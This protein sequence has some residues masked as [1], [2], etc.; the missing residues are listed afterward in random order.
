[1]ETMVEQHK[2]EVTAT[3]VPTT[4]VHPGLVVATPSIVMMEL[5]E[6]VDSTQTEAGMDHTDLNMA[7]AFSMGA[8]AELPSQVMP[9]EALEEEEELTHPIQA[10]GQE[11]D[12]PEEG[13]LIMVK[14]IA[15]AAAAH[16][17]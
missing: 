11:V 13:L 17:M 3:A 12:T 10:A 9:M 2:M 7:S 1:M 8:R 6:L 15:A 5:E 14:D 16:S 4:E